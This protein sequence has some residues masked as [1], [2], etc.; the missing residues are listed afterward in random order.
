MKYGTYDDF[1]IWSPTKYWGTGLFNGMVY[2]LLI[3]ED[4][5]YTFKTTEMRLSKDDSGRVV[6]KYNHLPYG[7]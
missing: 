2:A 5:S 1:T 7:P 3:A 4:H 6:D